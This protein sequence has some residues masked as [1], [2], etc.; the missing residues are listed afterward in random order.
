[1]KALVQK[2][3]L[4][5]LLRWLLI[6]AWILCAVAI[7]V[8]LLIHH[9]N[10]RQAFIKHAL[11]DICLLS[12]IYSANVPLPDMLEQ[13]ELASALHSG[14]NSHET[15]FRFNTVPASLSLGGPPTPIPS[16]AKAYRKG[17]CVIRVHSIWSKNG[18]LQIASIIL[19]SNADA[20]QQQLLIQYLEKPH[21]KAFKATDFNTLIVLTMLIN[22]LTFSFIV[23][24]GVRRG[25]RPLASLVAAIRQLDS[26]NPGP[27]RVQNPPREI[28]YIED[29]LNE[30]LQRIRDNVH[31]ER[32]FLNDAAHQLRTPVA[33]I[34]SQSELALTETNPELIRKRL[35]HIQQASERSATLIRQLL[36]LS[37]GY[38]SGSLGTILFDLP[39]LARSVALQWVGPAADA[40]IEL[41][42][43][44]E[45]NVL[46]N[47]NPEL[48]REAL[49]NILDNVLQHADGCTEAVVSVHRIQQEGHNQLALAVSDNGKGVHE[50]QLHHLF[51][52]FWINTTSHGSGIGLALVHQVAKAHQGRVDAALCQPYGLM[53][54][55]VLPLIENKTNTK[56]VSQHP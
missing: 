50:S 29:T 4:G 44:G 22:V 13:L 21:L 53:I 10:Q 42:Y 41:S 14:S 15:R 19:P 28:R 16:N 32:Q 56:S 26:S 12:E 33:G 40:N 55:M 52:R 1:M 11:N 37:R 38:E 23:S 20:Q 36:A 30:Q 31:R 46:Y 39:E 47:G 7:I 49:N 24:L 18:P 6:P 27:I 43:E 35:E 45:Q 25:L 51:D 17:N 8:S 3:M 34:L 5:S 9:R 2:T 54:R 48:I